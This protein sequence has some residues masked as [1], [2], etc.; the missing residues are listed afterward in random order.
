MRAA[1]AQ[2]AAVAV[3]AASTRAMT[4]LPPRPRLLKP[5]RPCLERGLPRRDKLPQLK[6]R[7]R[8]LFVLRQHGHRLRACACP[9]P[10]PMMIDQPLPL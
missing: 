7:L 1:A 5:T 2:M 10:L 6:A 4:P 8:P 3:G 9:H